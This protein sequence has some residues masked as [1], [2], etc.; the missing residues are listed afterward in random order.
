MY[1]C[2]LNTNICQ[3]YWSL[4]YTKHHLNTLTHTFNWSSTTDTY[5]PVSVTWTPSPLFENK[6]NS[7]RVSIATRT[8]FAVMQSGHLSIKRIAFSILEQ[9][10]N[11]SIWQMKNVF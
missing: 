11:L 4:L 1:I 2:R 9:I 6:S 10:C 7:G 3:P 5:Q 8:S